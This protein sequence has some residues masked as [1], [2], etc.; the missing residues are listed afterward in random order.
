VSSGVLAGKRGERSS[1]GC[2]ILDKASVPGGQAQKLANL[3]YGF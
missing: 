2:E 3:L 1:D